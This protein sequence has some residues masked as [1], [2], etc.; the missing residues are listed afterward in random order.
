[1]IGTTRA[2]PLTA[3]PGEAEEE[4]DLEVRV[5]QRVADMLEECPSFT[6]DVPTPDSTWNS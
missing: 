1:M 4:E 2:C 5:S 6:G 3:P